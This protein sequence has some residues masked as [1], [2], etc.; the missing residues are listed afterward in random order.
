M[1]KDLV[2]RKAIGADLPEILDIYEKAREFMK[3]SGNE[4]QWGD[5]YP[6]KDL[7]EGDIAAGNLYV[8]VKGAAGS[9]NPICGVF[10]L[11]IGDDPTYQEIIGG[12]HKDELYGTIH[13]IAGDGKTGGVFAA[14]IEFCSQQCDYLRI[15]T[16]ENNKVMQHM[17]EKHGFSYCGIIHV[18]DGS[19]RLAYDR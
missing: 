14:C 4:T 11:V 12:W 6:G 10:V 19:E 3:L 13:R 5:N 1:N 15:D 7:L 17:V 2:V 16:H 9:G 18:E 8:I